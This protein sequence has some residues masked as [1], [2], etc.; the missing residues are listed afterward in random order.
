MNKFELHLNLVNGMFSTNFC[1]RWLALIGKTFCALNLYTFSKS[2]TKHSFSKDICIFVEQNAN[3]R[4]TQMSQSA[5]CSALCLCLCVGVCICVEIAA[6][7][8]WYFPFLLVTNLYWH[9]LFLCVR[10]EKKTII[11]MHFIIA[12][13]C[14]LPQYCVCACACAWFRLVFSFVSFTICPAAI[15]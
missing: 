8:N 7:T 10:T 14:L 15:G 3:I 9:M 12:F 13:I 4:P 6:H 11:S 2:N 5:D 1:L